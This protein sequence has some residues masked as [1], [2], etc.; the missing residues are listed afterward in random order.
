MH[1]KNARR[2]IFSFSFTYILYIITVVAE[3]FA[4]PFFRVLFEVLPAKIF[5]ILL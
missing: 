2:A 5:A 3:L 1:L 4:V